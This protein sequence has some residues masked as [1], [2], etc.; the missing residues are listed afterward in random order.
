MQ[1]VVNIAFPYTFAI[2]VLIGE[3]WLEKSR[4]AIVRL[5]VF[6]SML[7]IAIT[8][9]L[10]VVP[11]IPN[12]WQHEADREL[13]VTAYILAGIVALVWAAMVLRGKREHI[14]EAPAEP[15]ADASKPYSAWV[16]KSPGMKAPAR[17]SWATRAFTLAP[18]RKPARRKS[19]TYTYDKE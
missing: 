6:A 19:V 1:D 10:Y 13:I 11:S 16:P 18:K 2:A 3:L 9:W 5:I 14:D 17:R 4:S 8:I 12:D 15:Q 7:A